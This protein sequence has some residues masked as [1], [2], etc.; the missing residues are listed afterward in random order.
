MNS[1]NEP[2]MIGSEFIWEPYSTDDIP[3]IYCTKQEKTDN[4]LQK[5]RKDPKYDLPWCHLESLSEKSEVR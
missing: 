3:T 2:F 1:L 4:P 5:S